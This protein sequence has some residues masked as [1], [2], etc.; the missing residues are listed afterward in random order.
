M[1]SLKYYWY[2]LCKRPLTMIAIFS[3]PFLVFW[4]FPREI[5]DFFTLN[6]VDN[7][8]EKCADYN[9]AKKVH[10]SASFRGFEFNRKIKYGEYFDE[11]TKCV[12]IHKQ[13][14]RL[15]MKRY[16]N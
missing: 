3:L 12:N 15:F 2:E 4:M 11:V 6:K 5:T 1:K 7:A 9:Y 13:S 10:P 16:G 14:P 8:I